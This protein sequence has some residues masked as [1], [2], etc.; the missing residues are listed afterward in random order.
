MVR[1]S[2]APPLIQLLANSS[3]KVLSVE[4]HNLTLTFAFVVSHLIKSL[5][6]VS[7]LLPEG[8]LPSYNPTSLRLL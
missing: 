6:A 1:V 7:M 8:D 3:G 2:A 5:M 4:H